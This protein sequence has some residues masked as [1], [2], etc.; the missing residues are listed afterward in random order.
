MQVRRTAWNLATVTTQILR[1]LARW[2]AAPVQAVRRT[3][4]NVRRF[5]SRLDWLQLRPVLQN[6]GVRRGR[7]V[8]AGF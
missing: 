2:K 5:F 7:F 8:I 1:L 3:L 6:E 4:Q